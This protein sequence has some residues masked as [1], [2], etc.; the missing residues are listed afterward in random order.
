MFA[1]VFDVRPADGKK[2]EYLALAQRLKPILETIDGFVSVERFVS[3]R[4]EGWMLSLSLWRD[5]KSVVRWRSEGEHHQVQLHSRAEVF[6]DYHLRVG[7]VTSD[8]EAADVRQQRLD[9]T[10]IGAAKAIGITEIA[11]E[12]DAPRQAGIEAVTRHAGLDRANAALVDHDLFES[13]YHPGKLLL[14][15]SWKT[16]TD[17]E[18]WAPNATGLHHRRVRNVRD[19]SLF[20]RREAPQFCPVID[21]RK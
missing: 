11:P 1:V 6:A 8:S 16:A 7:E 14:L 18:H 20:D 2:D 9:E 21:R 17:A 15:T 13:L 3:Q 12:T 19:Y 4:R 5:E 10:E